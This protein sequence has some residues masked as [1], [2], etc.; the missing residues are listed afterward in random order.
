MKKQLQDKWMNWICRLKST[1]T[2]KP[3][4]SLTLVT[5][6]PWGVHNPPVGLAY[7]ATFLRHH[8]IGVEVFD[9]NIALYR[10]IDPKWHKMWLPEYK[11]MWSHP[12]RYGEWSRIIAED[13]EWAVDRIIAFNTPIIGFSV[14]DPKESITIEVIL[15][16]FDKVPSKRFIL[17]GPAVST[18]QQRKVFINSLNG[19]IDYF[20]MGEGEE[21][22]L[23]IMQIYMR[24]RYRLPV[25]LEKQKPLLVQK[26]VKDIDTIPHPTYEEFDFSQY[27]GG[28][29]PVEWSRG[30]ISTCAYCKGRTL[31]GRYRMKKAENI[32]HEIES[33]YRNFQTDYF[34]V[35]DNLLNGNVV[36]LARVC[37]L[38][39]KRNI[40]IS[41]EGQGIPYRKMTYPLLQKMNAAG[42]RRLQ[43][44]LECGS[45][46]V[47]KNIGK[48]KVFSVYDAE[49]VIQYSH[50]AGIL[51]EIFIMVGLPG[52]NDAEFMKTLAFI[53]R[54]HEYIDRIKSVNTVHLVHGTD[55]FESASKFGL[56]LPEHSWYYLWYSR[57][58]KNNYR[59]RRKRAQEIIDLAGKLGIEI[60]EHN[61]HEGHKESNPIF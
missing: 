8:R 12:E 29:L 59:I 36:E 31:L 61:L 39:I 51:T 23:E 43:W 46:R 48:G 54:N 49:K 50:R 17:G 25:D 6:P 21:K 57:D 41:W 34:V 5:A 44:G 13:I 4:K 18:P 40:P 22:L 32:V 35:C 47:L 45:D 2:G 37:D 3:E 28:S 1:L 60:L 42:C 20:V 27:D 58:G 30:C 10:R 16:I 33:H 7:L 11:N 15:K 52:E 53:E 55:L 9:F 14:V 26:N 38:L 24:N 19:L 56:C